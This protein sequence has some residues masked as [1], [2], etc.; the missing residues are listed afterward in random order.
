MFNILLILVSYEYHIGLRISF[1][2]L[3]TF[4]FFPFFFFGV[5]YFFGIFHFLGEI[6]EIPFGWV[7]P[8]RTKVI[9]Y[10]FL[11]G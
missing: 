6:E 7:V 5:L 8:F 11:G 9:L 4:I 1:S 3:P 10:V 2:I